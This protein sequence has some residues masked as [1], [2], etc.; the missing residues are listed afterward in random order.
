MALKDAGL[1]INGE[2]CDFCA[3]SVVYLGY[4]VDEKG[5][6]PDEERVKP[7]VEYPAPK[8]IKQLRRF[9]G[10][11]GWY[12]R[13]IDWI[14]ERKLPLVKFLHKNVLFEWGD[15]QENAFQGLKNALI[16][17][18][19]LVDRTMRKFSRFKRM[20]RTLRSVAYLLKSTKMAN[21]PL[22]MSAE[23]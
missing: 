1:S 10:M 4:R 12:S 20:R 8:D 18:P 21:I 14:A 7:I 23:Y 9:L 13:F 3:S 2:K 11:I 16:K 5:L 19:V 6:S 22:R 15:E 17:A